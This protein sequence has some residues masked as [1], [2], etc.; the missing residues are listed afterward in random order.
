MH[1]VNAIGNELDLNTAAAFISN[2]IS[3]GA[4]DRS[5]AALMMAAVGNPALRPLDAKSR[6]ILRASILKQMLV[7]IC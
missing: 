2:L 3:C 5:A 7:S 1:T 4:I 6:D